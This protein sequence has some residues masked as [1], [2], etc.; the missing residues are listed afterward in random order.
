MGSIQPSLWFDNNAEEAATFYIDVFG[1]GEIRSV[2]RYTE[3][4]PGPEGTAQVVVFR[5]R[6]QE[7]TAINGGPIFTFTEAISFVIDCETQEEVDHFW[8]RLTEGGEPG[9]C[10][11]L[12]DR[13]GL[14]WQVVPNAL[15]RLLSDPDRDR[16]TRVTQAMLQM[17]KLDIAALEAA[18]DRAA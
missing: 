16:A 10:G 17:T 2:V 4:G 13:F 3:A 5:L 15:G 12:K 6:N 18:A 8:N 9:Q 11:W 14:S 1:D 7:F